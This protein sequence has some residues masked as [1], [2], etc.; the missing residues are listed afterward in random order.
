MNRC[1]LLCLL[2]L[3]FAVCAH[4]LPPLENQ[5]VKNIDVQYQSQDPKQTFDKTT[6]V[7]RL[8]TKKGD[9]F[10][11]TTF[12][13]DLK[14]LYGEFDRVE[15]LLSQ[16]EGGIN[17][18]LKI[19]PKPTIHEI[20]WEGNKR[21]SSKTLQ[22]ELG[23]KSGSVLNRVEF[24][25]S[26]NKVK[27]FYIKKGYFES[28]LSYTIVPIP[29]T[30]SVDM[31]MRVDEG[32]SGHIKKIVLTGFTKDERASL[33]DQIK[34][35]S[36][37]FLIS[38]LTGQGIYNE[39][40]VEQ[41][42]MM[43]LNYV[44]NEGYADA[45]V[46]LKVEEEPN[47]DKVSIYI[48][49]NRGPLY[50]FGVV[51]FDGNTLIPDDE[52]LKRF[53]IHPRETFSP[54]KIRDTVQGIKDLYGQKGHIEANVQYET[55]FME[56]EPIVNVDFT[57]DEGQEFRIGLIRVF[58][59]TSTKT[60][61]ILRESLL[62]PGELFDSRKLKATQSRLENIGYFKSVNVYAV[63][64]M[65][66][67]SLGSNYRDVYVEVEET[68]T[69]SISLFLGFSTI[70]DIYGG[71]DLTERNFN[72]AGIPCMFSDFGAL[73]G[74]G[75]YLHAKATVGQKQTNYLVSWMDPY[76]RDSLWRFGTELSYTT[77]QLQSEKY[78]IRTYGGSVAASYPLTVFWSFGT[79]YRIRY[80]H[81]NVEKSADASELRNAGVLSA[82]GGTLSYDSTDNA[83]KPHMGL[84]SAF[85]V[86][87]AGIFGKFRFFKVAFL[88]TLYQPLWS[89]GTMKYRAE[90]RT[91]QPF[92]DDFQRVPLSERFFLGGD[93]TVRGFKPF[94]MGKK[95]PGGEPLGGLSSLLL[96]V[97]YN[98]SIIP[99]LDVFV[100]A[101]AGSIS[102]GPFKISRVQGSAGGGMRI[103][104]MNK[105]PIMIGW[106]YPVN[107]R[108][109]ESQKFFFSM[110][111]QF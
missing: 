2:F 43:I 8:K 65:D 28:Q 36:Y 48:D 64:S 55:H 53:Q 62:I 52:V 47:S 69:G 11:Q 82:M 44:H 108:P 21:Y 87:F 54:E 22:K 38:W 79:K 72:I 81:S 31:L 24:N 42:R 9:P 6:V 94:I 92:G 32:P 33:F 17:I 18:I 96:S 59:N 51:T 61:V 20:T 50:H 58:G 25:K 104:I 103:E 70:D 85:D 101:D 88:N 90:Y 100:F 97:E 75:E 13:T 67:L 56:H 78:F 40:A 29:N 66:D 16:Q 95:S 63:K 74:A 83:Y 107:A 57:I 15:P 45:R 7:G 89:R 34:T 106:G 35:K 46:N 37:N 27:E 105:A 26:F 109:H 3:L 76:F 23:V 111:G 73:R 12:D 86:E 4:A 49:L 14:M 19:W 91:I 93:T 30:N 77:S 1:K 41:D 60:N 39:E 98:Q 5:R 99:M 80:T 102:Q 110:G 71:L 84:R 10:S 68:T